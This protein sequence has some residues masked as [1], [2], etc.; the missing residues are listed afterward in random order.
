MHLPT[1]TKS[2]SLAVTVSQSLSPLSSLTSAPMSHLQAMMSSGKSLTARMTPATG[3]TI[4]AQ[5]VHLAVVRRHTA[6][7]VRLAA[8]YAPQHSTC[9]TL[10][11]V[12]HDATTPADCGIT[13]KQACRHCATTTLC[14]TTSGLRFGLLRHRVRNLRVPL[15]SIL[16]ISAMLTYC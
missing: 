4:R 15:A 12:T 10:R 7:G 11:M 14:T 9:T 3:V 6:H 8:P 5:H 16:P 2:L 13:P 1:L